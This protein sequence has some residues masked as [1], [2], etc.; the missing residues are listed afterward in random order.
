MFTT[1]IAIGIWFLVCDH[2][3]EMPTSVNA[4]TYNYTWLT[5][6]KTCFTQWYAHKSDVKIN[7]WKRI[8]SWRW[9]KDDYNISNSPLWMTRV[10]TMFWFRPEVLKKID[11]LCHKLNKQ[12]GFL[13]WLLFY[14]HIGCFSFIESPN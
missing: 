3:S 1:H 8:R 11:I 5:G 10:K 6:I 9:T 12:H 2:A 14:G 7:K 4:E 13:Y